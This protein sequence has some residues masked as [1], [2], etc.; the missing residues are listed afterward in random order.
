MY[1]INV[2]FQNQNFGLQDLDTED[3]EGIKAQ[4]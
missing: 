3:I 1:V 4:I 2:E